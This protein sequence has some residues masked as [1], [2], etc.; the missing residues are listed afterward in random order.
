MY[1]NTRNL[2][3]KKV[4]PVCGVKNFVFPRKL[5]FFTKANPEILHIT[6]KSH[7]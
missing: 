3:D 1:F 5:N 6:L 2:C 4:L 7:P